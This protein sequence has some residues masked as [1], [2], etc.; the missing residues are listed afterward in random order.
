MEASEVMRDM[1]V[2]WI[3][4]SRNVEII[5]NMTIDEW[6]CM[7]KHIKIET[8]TGGLE[9]E[10]LFEVSFLQMSTHYMSQLWLLWFKHEDGAETKRK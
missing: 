6:V 8:Q 10:T 3:S 2:K 1:L 4:Q 9:A 7:D 5:P